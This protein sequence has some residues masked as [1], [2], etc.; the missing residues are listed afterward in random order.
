MA[1][2][3][4]Y[5]VEEV[6]DNVQDAPP[7]LWRGQALSFQNRRG[8]GLIQ[9]DLCY[10]TT[11]MGLDKYLKRRRKSSWPLS[12][13]TMT[14]NPC[15]PSADSQWNSVGNRECRQYHLESMTRTRP[16]PAEQRPRPNT[17]VVNRSVSSGNQKHST[18]NSDSGWKRLTWTKTSPTVG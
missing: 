17:R 8:R 1:D 14:G 13:T 6:L 18:P 3:T 15:T 11:T 12:K 4:W 16:V 7:Q 5:K 10:E 9:L 2:R